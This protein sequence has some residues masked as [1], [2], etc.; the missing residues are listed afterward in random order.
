MSLHE[1]AVKDSGWMLSARSSSGNCCFLCLAFKDDHKAECYCVLFC[2]SAGLLIT[3]APQSV[4][5][6]ILLEIPAP[7]SVVV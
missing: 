6:A 1:L 2:F 5:L 4:L 7:F 3:R